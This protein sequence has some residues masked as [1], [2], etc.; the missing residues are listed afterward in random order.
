MSWESALDIWSALTKP[1]EGF[2]VMAQ[3]SHQINFFDFVHMIF[4]LALC[5]IVL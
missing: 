1:E 5:L 3:V 2:Y 4:Q